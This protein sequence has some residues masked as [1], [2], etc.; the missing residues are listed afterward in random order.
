MHNSLMHTYPSPLTSSATGQVTFEWLHNNEPILS[1]VTQATENLQ[2][3]I[4]SVDLQD[5]GEYTC[6]ANLSDGRTI[7]PTSAGTLTVLGK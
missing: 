2:L 5:T 3:L 1:D 6:R 7:G 4:D